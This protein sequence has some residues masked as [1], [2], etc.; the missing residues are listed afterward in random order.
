MKDGME[1]KLSSLPIMS[2]TYGNGK[3]ASIRNVD[4]RDVRL[5]SNSCKLRPERPENENHL[6]RKW[7]LVR[8]RVILLVKEMC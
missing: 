7:H 3:H 1:Q 6:R 8:G 4:G 2:S 5:P